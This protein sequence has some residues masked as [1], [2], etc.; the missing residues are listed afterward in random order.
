MSEKDLAGPFHV[1]PI[2]RTQTHARDVK[3]TG[4][5]GLDRAHLLIE[6]QE[7]LSLAWF[8]DR[9]V[10]GVT[11]WAA[12][13]MVATTSNSGLRGAVQVVE[14]NLREAAH[15]VD[16]RGRGKFFPAPEQ[17]AERGETLPSDR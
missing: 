6:H 9:Y 1:S 11:L 12:R 2:A 5:T 3:I 15:P 7:P 4:F 13:H 17:P 8:A 10:D 16:Q 14:I